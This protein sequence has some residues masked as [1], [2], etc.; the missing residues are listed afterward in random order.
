MHCY[1]YILKKIPRCS[2]S[3]FP[4]TRVI[5]FTRVSGNTRCNWVK[6]YLGKINPGSWERSLRSTI[7][8]L[9]VHVQNFQKMCA[10]MYGTF[11]VLWPNSAIFSNS[12]KRTLKQKKFTIYTVRQS[13][14]LKILSLGLPPYHLKILNVL[15]NLVD[16][17]HA[18]YRHIEAGIC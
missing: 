18:F 9:G 11:C 4:R 5:K 6:I 14:F 17:L 8:A 15:E 13:I 1:V 7:I 10:S 3:A 2:L 12:V 16:M